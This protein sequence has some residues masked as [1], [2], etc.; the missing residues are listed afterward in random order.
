MKKVAIIGASKNRKK[1][2]N[3]AVRAHQ[4]QGWQVYPINPKE[5]EIEGIK[6]YNDIN[7]IEEQLDKV[8]IYLPPEVGIHELEKL[9]NKNIAE[10]YINPGA[11][12]EELISRGKELGLNLI[13]ACSI[14]S[15]GEQPINYL[16]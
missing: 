1:Y 15:I 10:V 12:S 6:C 13:Q 2:G 8:S 14:V 7:E 16:N 9:A 11:E 3:I 4:K 5:K